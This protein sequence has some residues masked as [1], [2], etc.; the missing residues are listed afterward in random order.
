MLE[1]S[2]SYKLSVL[3]VNQF[4]P[5]SLSHLQLLPKSVQNKI[6]VKTKI[7]FDVG[8]IIIPFFKS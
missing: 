1:P 7:T 2:I 8:R 3:S 5:P 4:L 6:N